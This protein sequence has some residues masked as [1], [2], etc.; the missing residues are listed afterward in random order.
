[1][2]RR[3]TL[4]ARLPVTDLQQIDAICDRFEAAWS[5][6]QT[7]DLA[8]FLA[9]APASSAASLFGDLLH[10]ELEYRTARGEHLDARSYHERF[11]A[12]RVI[13]A[14]AFGSSGEVLIATKLY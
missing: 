4:D 14:A 13:I 11:P 7:P 9:E 6:G 1:M 3:A 12:F 10:I 5:K 2:N 8:S